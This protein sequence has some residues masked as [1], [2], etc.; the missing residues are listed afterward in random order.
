MKEN[1]FLCKPIV[2]LEIENSKDSVQNVIIKQRKEDD[3]RKAKFG[4]HGDLLKLFK[5]LRINRLSP[6]R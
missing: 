3:N 4:F 6:G 2:T 1:S 5:Y